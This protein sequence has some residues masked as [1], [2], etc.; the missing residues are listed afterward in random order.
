MVIV[1]LE[2]RVGVV[3]IIDGGRLVH[4]AQVAQALGHLEGHVLIL[5]VRQQAQAVHVV[6][7]STAHMLCIQ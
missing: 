1:H 5:Q 3:H 6:L 2:L 4:G 7:R